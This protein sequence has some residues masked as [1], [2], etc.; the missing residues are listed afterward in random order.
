MCRPVNPVSLVGAAAF[1]FGEDHTREPRGDLVNGSAKARGIQVL[2]ALFALAACAREPMGPTADDFPDE[3]APDPA[4]ATVA[5]VNVNVVTMRDDR[6]L[7]RQTVVV[8]GGRIVAIGDVGGVAVPA[9]AFRIEGQGRFLI[10]GLAD[11]HVHLTSATF[12]NLRNDF[13]LWLANGVTTIRVMWGSAGILAER[14]RIEDGSVLGPTLLVASPGIDGPGGTWT[15]STPPVS[16]LAE[17]RERAQAHVAAGYDFLKVYNDL[18]PAMYTAITDAARSAGVPVVGHVP[19]RVGFESVVA[20]GQLTLEH[21]IGIKLQAAR[22]FTGG[23]LD[24]ARV[25]SLAERGRQA[26]AWF[27]P[28]ITVDVLSLAR[29]A[30]IR[31]STEISFVSPG[32]RNFFQSGFHNGLPNDVAERERANQATITRILH[33]T[34][35]NL[36]VGTDAGFGWILPGT[37]I[38]E[39]LSHFVRAGLSRHAALRAA[40]SAAARSVSRSGEFGT[41]AEG[42]RADLVLVVRNPLRDLDTLRD[43]SGVMVRGR[44][45]SRGDLRTRLDAIRQSYGN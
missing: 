35:A 18:T 20:A 8:R 30:D 31:S 4:P 1:P 5:F 16:T 45:L 41:V 21:F 15:A 14:G 2:V 13:M 28:T 34:G 44:W 33:E 19:S 40:T 9:D 12:V 37:S 43:P 11:M 36:L 26:G 32:M 23:S 3:P 22:P 39:E 10:P 27:T 25:R 38:H 6:V 42:A 7:E 29:A 17:A 24:V